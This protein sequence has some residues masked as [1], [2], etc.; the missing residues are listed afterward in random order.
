MRK[1]LAA[2][3]RREGATL[4]MTLLATLDVLL[5][6]WTGQRDV[7]VGT[8]VSNRGRV[9]TEGLMGFFINALVLR[10]EVA[11]EAPFTTLLERVREVCLGAYAHQDM[12]FERLVQELSPDPDPSRAPLFQVIF[13]MQNAPVR[14]AGLPGLSLRADGGRERHG[15]VRPDLRHGR[16]RAALATRASACPSSTTPTSSRRPPSTG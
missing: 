16:G 1:G 10:V 14:A 6:R 12:P 11:E 4:Y 2:L 5:H 3:A 15:Q 13:T 9:E 8:S 7:V